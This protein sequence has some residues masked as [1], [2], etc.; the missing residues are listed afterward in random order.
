MKKVH[1]S[2]MCTNLLSKS[3]PDYTHW[4]IKEKYTEQCISLVPGSSYRKNVGF[5]SCYIIASLHN[6]ASHV[7]YFIAK[8]IFFYFEYVYLGFINLW[9]GIMIAIYVAKLLL[10]AIFALQYRV[11]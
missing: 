11:T 6:F 8:L 9:F 1:L 4:L 10:L 2:H 5:A 3:V 7:L